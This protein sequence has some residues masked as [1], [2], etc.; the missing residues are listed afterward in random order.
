MSLIPV[1][2]S[3]ALAIGYS[4]VVGWILKYLVGSLSGNLFEI[5]GV[6]GYA[7]TFNQ[8]AASFGN[9]GWHLTALAITFAIMMYGIA[10]GIE[11]G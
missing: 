6:E 4:V 10:S 11:K 5:S 2:G 9:I 3:L 1:L 8:T 7:D